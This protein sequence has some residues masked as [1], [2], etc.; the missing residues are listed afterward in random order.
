MQCTSDANV[1]LSVL[2]F[3]MPP[4]VSKSTLLTSVDFDGICR[5]KVLVF[6][7]PNLIPNIYSVSSDTRPKLR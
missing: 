1:V 7:F 2:P 3:T 5:K 6:R 4:F